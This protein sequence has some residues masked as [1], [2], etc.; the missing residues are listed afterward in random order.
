MNSVLAAFLGWTL[1][2]FDFFVLTFVIADI[3]NT[4]GKSRSDI[5]LT[6]TLALA[7]RPLG[8]ILF[9]MMADRIGRRIPLMLNILLYSGLTVASGLAP[10]FTTF[11]VLRVLFGI[12]MGGQWGVGASLALESISPARRGLVSGFLQEGYAVGNLLAAI[13]FREVYP[14]F[15]WRS[16]FMLGGVPALLSLFILFKVE[17]SPV[18]RE[19]RT[20]W[21]TYASTAFGHW[22]RFLY[23]VLLMTMV[24]L[25]AHGTQDMYPTFLQQAREYTPRQTA[26]ITIISMIGACLGGLAIGWFSD[27]AGRKRAMVVAALCGLLVVPLWIAAPNTA[28]IVV[29]VFL[30]QFFIQ[31][32]GGVIPAQM[33]ELTPGHLRGLFPGLAYQFGIVAASGITYLEAVLSE[34]LPFAQ[35]MGFLVAGIFVLSAVVFAFGPENKGVSFSASPR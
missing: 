30:I 15:G 16:L 21:R 34:H 25:M 28:L 29:G 33:N 26:D 1:D 4:F 27:L 7:T 6:I 5:A 14:R 9:G 23:L 8:A 31:G 10:N 12:A 32:A 19:H 24:A 3:A 2:S 17:D 22:R 11:L 35:A 13:A 18:W 20:D